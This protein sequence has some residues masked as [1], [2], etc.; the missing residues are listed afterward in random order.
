M[1]STPRETETYDVDLAREERWIVHHVLVTRADEA[2]SEREQPPAWLVDLFER[3]EA[4][5]ETITGRQARKLADALA[6][7]A[8]DDETPTRDVDTATDVVAELEAT[9]EE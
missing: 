7:Y 9:L 4:D 6:S 1:S 8:N 5:S 2:L 3:I